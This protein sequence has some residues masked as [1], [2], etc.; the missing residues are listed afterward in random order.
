MFPTTIPGAS[1]AF[2][3]NGLPQYAAHLICAA[4]DRLGQECIVVGSR[5]TV[6][7]EGM[8]RVLGQKVFWVDS[9]KPVSWGDLDLEPPSIFFQSGWSYPAFGALGREAKAAGA[10]IIGLSDANWRGNFRQKV[11][12]S[13][14]F[15]LLHRA[16][17]DAMLVPGEQGTRLMRHFGM[18][19]N[20]IRKGMYGADP[21]LFNGGAPLVERAKTFLY[22]G[23]FIERKNVL[24]LAEAFLRFSTHTPGWTLRIIGSGE[25]GRFLPSAANIVVEDFVQPE[26]LAERYRAARFF[27]LPSLVEAWGLVVHEAALCGCALILSDAIGSAD[28]LADHS[29]STRFVAGDLRA[30]ES[31]LTQAALFDK[32]CLKIAEATSRRL[33]ARFGPDRFAHEVVRLVAHLAPAAALQAVAE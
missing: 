30:L 12:G 27:V 20:R 17:F 23:Q 33:A 18:P 31:A 22:V 3:W 4:I 25:Q 8:E 16:H 24:G 28:D 13:V 7:V 29:N 6:P 32:K 10:K 21:N 5:P 19:A 15:R 11:L 14:G 2:S 1:V 26:H 9:T